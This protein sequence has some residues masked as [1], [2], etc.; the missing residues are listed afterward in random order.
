[1]SC[2]KLYIFLFLTSFMVGSAQ[3][4]EVPQA[5]LEAGLRVVS[6]TTVD[7]EEPTA[8][9]IEAPPGS[10]GIGITNV[11]KVPGSVRIFSPDGKILFD[12]GDY[13]KKESGM[14]IKV[15]GNTSARYDKKPF[16]VKLEKKGDLLLR[17][18][19]NLRDKNW[20]L[21]PDRNMLLVTG[22][23]IGD[24][25]GMAWAPSYEWVNVVING[26]Y[27]GVY[28]LA[29]AVERNET[30]RIIT[31]ETGFVTE[32]DPYWWNENGEYLNS[33]WLP[34]FGWTMKYPD[35]EDFTEEQKDYV[36]QTMLAFEEIIRTE[37][38][39]DLVDIDSFC[40]WVICQDILGTLD[41][42]GTNLYIAK[43]DNTPGSKLYIPVLWDVDSAE[44]AV[45]DW[46]AVHREPVISQLFNNANKRFVRRY[47][48]LY[49]EIADEI[50]QK[51]QEDTDRLSTTEYDAYNRSVA[52]DKQRWIEGGSRAGSTEDNVPHLNSWIATRK[53]WLDNA[54]EELDRSTSGVNNISEE[55][56]VVLEVRMENGSLS[57]VF[58]GSDYSVYSA[59]GRLIYSGDE[60]SVKLPGRGI[61]V[62]KAGNISKKIIF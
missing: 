9:S 14:T 21:L 28:L 53:I 33:C 3:A 61:Y 44:D 50:F 25:A 10:W 57:V 2:Y 58:S 6:V 52:L 22:F 41:G 27:R 34:Q 45:D 59:D 62:V 42:G 54:I 1:M 31:D 39:E 38:Y 43:K 36:Q 30:C 24:W 4:Q 19:K 47:I 29:E 60:T 16:K 26:D 12:S 40:R 55:A 23:F 7:G 15:R 20:V 37:D 49:H 32:R 18:D 51:W 48:E 17:D 35:F 11:N 46:S 13:L 5:V 56:G 8:E